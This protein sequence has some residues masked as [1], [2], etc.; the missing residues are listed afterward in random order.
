MKTHFFYQS[1]GRSPHVNG[2]GSRRLILALSLL[3]SVIV[4]YHISIYDMEWNCL[5]FKHYARCVMVTYSRGSSNA[6]RP[7]L[8]ADSMLS[9]DNSQI[10]LLSHRDHESAVKLKQCTLS[11]MMV[12]MVRRWFHCVES[13]GASRFLAPSSAFGR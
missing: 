12:V 8:A 10:S 2:K 3:L 11:V 6:L 4:S 5:F 9:T 7:C 1:R 13:H